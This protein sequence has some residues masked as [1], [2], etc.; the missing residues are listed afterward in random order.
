[1][2]VTVAPAKKMRK[3]CPWTCG[4]KD[5]RSEREEERVRARAWGLRDMQGF[6]SRADEVR[7]IG[8]EREPEN[9]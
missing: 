6:E 1:M 2:D 3:G 5:G 8:G 4:G 9:G 7:C